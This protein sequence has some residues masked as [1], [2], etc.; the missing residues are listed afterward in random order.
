MTEVTR[1]EVTRI[2]V[3]VGDIVD[4]VRPLV[5]AV[6]EARR[7]GAELHV[8]RAW[9]D[10]G[11]PSAMTGYWRHEL[12]DAAQQIVI[13]AFILGLGGVPRDLTVRMAVQEGFASDV[14]V[15]YANQE[16]DVL[17]I[18]AGRHHR[19]W[20]LGGITTRRCVRRATCPVLVVPPGALARSM[21]VRK[22]VRDLHRELRE[23]ESSQG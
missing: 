16:S 2:V 14:L 5:T 12:A 7:R 1:T 8:V 15:G 4:G 22:L 10:R 13:D 23:F 19:L 9:Q 6:T 11:Q 18:G 20:P 3:G 21:P 17:V